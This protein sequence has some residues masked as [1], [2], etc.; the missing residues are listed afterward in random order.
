MTSKELYRRLLTYVRRYRRVFVWALLGN[1]ALAATEPVLAALLKPLLDGSFVRKDIS[2]PLLMPLALIGVFLVRGIAGYI[3][4]V[5][6][7][8]VATSVVMDLR[9]AM[10]QRLMTL[11]ARS[12]DA[13]P[14]G[15][16]LSRFNYD[17]A[18]V[19]DIATEVLVTLVK[20][21]LILVGLLAWVFYL[22]WRLSLITLVIVPPMAWVILVVSRRL[23]KL[24]RALQDSVGELTRVAQEAI[25]AQKVIKVYGGTEYE[26]A[27]FAKINNW[28][29]RYQ[30]K[31][32]AAAEAH[33]PLVQL[34]MVLGL[35]VVIAIAT[36]ESLAGKL[37]VGGFV[38]LIGAIALMS[39][40]IKR[41]TK[42]NERLQ[43]G[44]A[45][46][47]SVFALIDEEAERDNGSV[48]MLRA[49]G[50]LEFRAVEFAY[51]TEGGTVLHGIDLA[52]AA[53]ENV[54]LV[55]RSGSG[56]TTLA[57]LVPRFY[58][59]TAGEILLDGIPINTLRLTD[60]RAQIAYVGQDIVLFDDTVA[61]NIAYGARGQATREQ[62]IAAARQAHALEFIE[63]LPQGFETSIGENGVRLSGGQRQRLAIAR[64]LI[65][66]API[67][68]LDEATSALDSASELRVREALERL[69]S[70][71][72]CLVIAHRL[73]T[74]E[75]ADRIVVLE[76]GRI[77][78]QGRHDVLM[79]R[80]PLYQQLYRQ[81]HSEPVAVDV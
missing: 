67:L 36:Q 33:V 75:H 43:T 77:V 6:M 45:A 4:T 2:H 5:G 35:A 32:V 39:A 55:G 30:M 78:D 47:E 1:V 40:P 20:D 19:M 48:G 57:H 29:R 66:D 8:S 79:S 49:T 62:V 56:K 27:R 15:V 70:G 65:K 69:R 46:A 9:T 7:R 3:G 10:F 17:V 73:S 64:A 14:S 28:V 59:P 16:T 60:L 24:N 53:G 74:V 37:T 18:R 21:S 50:A 26:C 25:T 54:A 76:Q 80:S 42:V 13:R 68:I 22:N 61:A 11:P 41:L 38:S 23:R 71:R 58:T 63:T 44:L 52:L 12:F 81:Q 72:T 51:G 31:M 34:L